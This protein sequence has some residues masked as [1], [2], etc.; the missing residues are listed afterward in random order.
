MKK[1]TSSIKSEV[2][3]ES[4]KTGPEGSIDRRKFIEGVSSAAIGLTI[5]PSTVLGGK[6]IA[7]SDKINVAYIGLG[8]QG[9]RQLPDIIQ[10][11]DVQITAVCDPQRKAINYYDWGPTWLRDQM[12]ELMG[13]PNWNTGGNNTIPGGL[14]NGK[15]IVDAYYTKIGKNYKC[16]AYTDFRELLE[17]EKDLDAIQVMTPDHL[18][19]IICAAAL[20]RNIAVSVHKPL[21]NRLIEANKVFEMANKS[22]LTT[23]LQP[24]DL[25]G[26]DM[27]KIMKWINNGAIGELQEVHNW[28][29]RPVWPQ[30]ANLPSDTPKV[31]DGFDWDI[32]LGPEADRPYHPH[33]TNMTFRGWY[34]FGGGSMAD[35]GHYSLWTVFE[36]LKLGKPT[37]VEPNFNH[38]CGITEKGTAYKI[39]N[40]F[41]FP[42]AS[43]MRFKYPAVD[44]RGAIDLVWYDGGM[45]PPVPKEFYDRGIDFPSEGIMFKGSKGIIMTQGFRA[46]DPYLLSEGVKTSE[47]VSAAAGAVKMPGIQRFIEGIKTGQQIEGGFRQAWPITEAVNLYAVALRS[48]KTLHYDADAMKIKNDQKANEYLDRTYRKGWGLDEV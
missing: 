23:H 45:R 18:H 32:W 5:V 35:M 20:K 6:H 4:P 43:S 22:G 30:Y 13:N 46:T 19:G 9:L 44:G 1:N 14:D 27:P 36:H 48:Q 12:R 26:E 24:W 37:I 39:K 17:K 33:Y 41:S 29:F 28:S 38:V 34:D 11:A 3:E 8:T 42:F 31:P 40:D 25:N 15:E 2:H 7:P 16:N 47:E 21:S 10:L